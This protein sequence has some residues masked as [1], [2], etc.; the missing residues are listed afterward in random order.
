MSNLYEASHQ[1]ATRPDDQRFGSIREMFDA[2]KSYY[3][4]ARVAQVPFN[5]LRVEADATDIKLIGK[6]ALPATLTHYAFGQLARRIGAP[7]EYLR[8]LAPTLAA[9]NINYGLKK[10]GE[11]DN[12]AK[13]QLL[14]HENGKLVTR[15]VT[16]ASYDR[17]W[18]YELVNKVQEMLVP[19]GWVVPPA[20]PVRDGQKGTRKATAADILPNQADFGLS[21]KIG[22]DIAPA[23]LYASDH[24]MFM[25]LVNQLDPVFDGTKFLHRGVFIQNS[26][27]GDKAIKFKLFT[28]DNVC[29][30]HIIWGVGQVAEVSIRHMKSSEKKV[31]NTFKNAVQKWNVMSS[32][33]ASPKEIEANIA[34]A[35]SKEIAATKEEVLEAVF[36]FAKKKNLTLLNRDTLTSAYELTENT[37][38]Y[39]APTTVW[40][41]VNG[42]TEL[43]QKG[44]LHTDSRTDMDVQ[45]GRLMEMA[46]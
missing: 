43:S 15:A 29:G 22:D 4:N 30:N 31:G 9:Q 23:G 19:N 37:P 21:V 33:M 11:K 46:F 3:N 12:E 5:T 45:A 34:A 13:A 20:R 39:G 28:Y 35:R 6:A 16:S 10:L 41:M 2:C 27:V 42:L 38:R 24:D 32:K 44:A 1:W 25:F 14:F 40:G 7:A 8:D 17:V 36:G 18:N 26:E